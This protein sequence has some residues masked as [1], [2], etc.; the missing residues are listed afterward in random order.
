M[1][2]RGKGELENAKGHKHESIFTFKMACLECFQTDFLPQAK[3]SVILV[4][5]EWTYSI[6][7]E[8]SSELVGTFQI[9]FWYFIS[10]NIKSFFLK[11]FKTKQRL[12]L[13]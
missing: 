10:F 6:K 1:F 9:C 12:L 13:T 7:V 4:T 11:V 8:K 2:D 5:K 3:R